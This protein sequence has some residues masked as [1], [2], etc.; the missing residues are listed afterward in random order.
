MADHPSGYVTLADAVAF[1]S[2][3]LA[4]AN[5]GRRSD[6]NLAAGQSV[7]RQLLI[8][9]AVQA[10][11]TPR[12]RKS[13]TVPKT[14]WSTDYAATMFATGAAR[15]ADGVGVGAG[16]VE[17]PVLVP[18]RTLDSALKERSRR[19]DAARR[20][21]PPEIIAA[22]DR[23][24][25]ERLVSFDRGGLARAAEAL[26]WSFPAHKVASIRNIIRAAYAM[27]RGG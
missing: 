14:L 1:A 27:R 16:V 2:R 19:A 10:I 8:G 17:G 5:G 15:F 3:S 26:A 11:V 20:A 21:R 18:R 25:E 7:L 12:R 13:R 4:G 22:F 24:C 9:G 23:L 6:E